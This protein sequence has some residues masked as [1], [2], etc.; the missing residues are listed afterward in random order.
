[1]SVTSFFQN[2]IK[3]F[4]EKKARRSLIFKLDT[5]L[6]NF[7]FLYGENF[8]METLPQFFNIMEAFIHD[9]RPGEWNIAP[10]MLKQVKRAT[11]RD[12]SKFFRAP[13]GQPATMENTW[14]QPRGHWA[15]DFQPRTL[16]DL[17]AN[18]DESLESFGFSGTAKE[19]YAARAEG[20]MRDQMNALTKSLQ[21]LN[22][23]FKNA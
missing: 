3:T 11:A 4:Q 1:M 22:K 12:Q 14:L 13:D 16:A 9:I 18:G 10:D 21:E 8:C 19:L 7:S 15:E 2:K 23:V 20:F 5:A 17:A 6:K